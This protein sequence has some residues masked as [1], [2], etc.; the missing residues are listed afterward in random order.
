MKRRDLM[1]YSLVAAAPA[2]LLETA[3]SANQS[4]GWMV[5]GSNSQFAR[6]PA[7]TAQHP[8]CPVC[9]MPIRRE[10][11]LPWEYHHKTY[12]FCSESC[13]SRFMTDPQPFIEA[14]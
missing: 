11:A 4:T 9:E 12:Y 14:A 13:K 10:A 6:K 2:V 7:S 5:P 3:A 1:K 8:V